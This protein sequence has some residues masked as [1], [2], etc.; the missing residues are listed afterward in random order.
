M[1]RRHYQPS[2]AKEG[3]VGLKMTIRHCLLGSC[4]FLLLASACATSSKTAKPGRGLAKKKG[5]AAKAAPAEAKA[6]PSES[7]SND[8]SK[9]KV[10]PSAAGK[11]PKGAAV[12]EAKKPP[13]PPPPPPPQ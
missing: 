8:K 13:P 4:A 12:V 1:A 5:S 3:I 6:A 10:Q 11:V 7:S 2:S 9:S